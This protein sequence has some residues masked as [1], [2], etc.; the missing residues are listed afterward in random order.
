MLTPIFH[1]LLAFYSVLVVNCVKHPENWKACSTDWHIW[2]LPEVQR[3]I[4]SLSP[5]K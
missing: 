4:M 3:G 1:Y 2:L 5:E